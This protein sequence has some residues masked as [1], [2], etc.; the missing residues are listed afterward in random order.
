[1]KIK[2]QKIF[3]VLM[4]MAF[5][6]FSSSTRAAATDG[7]TTLG[8]M[9]APGW[10]GK[11]LLFHSGQGMLAITPLSDDVVRVRFTTKPDFGRD[12]SY[13]VINHD[14]G[15]PTAKAD[16]DAD[17]ATLT[18][19]SLKVKVQY[20]P[21]RFSFANAAGE[22][23]DADDP[24]QGTSLAGSAFRVAK[25]LDDDEHVYGLG[26]K[27]GSL[28]KRGWK[29]GGYN[30]VMWNSDTPAYDS[31]TDP[32]YV[33]V[34]FF[35]VLRRGESHGIFLDNTWRSYFDIG[36]E[37]RNLLTFG[38]DGG[39]IDY[40][41]INGPDPKQVIERYTALTGRTPLPPLW[42]LGY[43]QC[44][45]SYYPES[46]VRLLADT[47]RSKNV[48][49]DGLWLDIHYMDGYKPFTWDH[50]RFPDPKKMISDLRAQGFHLVTILDGHPPALK[51]YA[52]YDEGI[53]G[54]DFVKNPDGSVYEGP[55][56]PSQAAKDPAPSV[57]PDFSRPATREWWGS[58]YKSLLD[59][60]VAGIWNDMDEPSVFNTPSGT[61]PLDVIFDNDGQPTTHQELHNVFGQLMSRSTFEGLSKLQPDDRAFV[62]TR[63]SFAGGQRYA[64]VWTGDATADW[65]SLRQSVSMLLGLGVSGFPFVGSD[66]GG[67]VRM[68]SAELCTRWL[69]V[70][71]FSPFMR[72]H[73]EIATPDKE[74]WSFGWQYEKINK[75]AIELRYELLP[76]IYNEM[77]KAS[78]T[79]V[80]ALRPLFLDYPS[81]ENAATIE[82]EFLFGSDLLVAPVLWE[83]SDSRSVYLPP[84]DWFDYWTGKRYSGDTTIQ[85]PV[86]IDSIP[87]FVRGGGFIFRQPVVQYTGQMPG[88]PLRVL[89]APAAQS[90]SS[91]YEDDGK[92]LQ[93]QKGEFVKRKFQL[94]Q[95]ALST[96][97]SISDPEGPYRP[98]K[99]DLYLETWMDREPSAVTEQIG[100]GDESS[101]SRFNP[102]DLA[103]A[104]AGWA[105]TNGLLTVKDTDHFKRTE[106]RI[107]D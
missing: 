15:S 36:H 90:E 20:S 21:L 29:L 23:L 95:N 105:Y 1:M 26:E 19:A 38:A 27:I 91:L 65:S 54:N 33:S 52:P 68:P 107:K 93:Y 73:T 35:M 31:S 2:S 106:F 41:F 50:D 51:G 61:M 63:S 67:F 37:Q 77:Q 42:S 62:L 98:A 16:I 58:L 49:A 86:T 97:V 75:R 66:I 76:Y 84:G 28:D 71:V 59:V 99:R 10:D 48:P 46:R 83:G 81:V 56:W 4:A 80:P 32:L 6:G 39:D 3:A 64:A 11:T 57:F 17:S 45:W 89:I 14:L 22:V 92:S 12:H 60:G 85:I 74:P 55:V 70:A 72:M 24:A 101:L 43:N 78:V 18:T 69:Q 102:D 100:N 25:Q 8:A 103:G 53:A 104:S 47:F 87:I 30:Y 34:P 44:R 9:P 94:T 40:Y 7:W 5:A 13:A 96:V 82:D 79:G 88:N